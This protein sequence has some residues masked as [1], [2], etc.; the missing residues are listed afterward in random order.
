MAR[1]FV[2]LLVVLVPS[3]TFAATCSPSTYSLGTI[4]PRFGMDATQMRSVLAQASDVWN[5]LGSQSLFTFATSSGIR[6]SLVYDNR[7]KETDAQKATLAQFGAIKTVFDGIELKLATIA[8]STQEE[9]T[10]LSAQYAAYKAD[11]DRFNADVAASNAHGGASPEDY[12]SFQS[13]Q[14]MLATRFSALKTQEV[15]LNDRA[16]RINALGDV[17][18]ALA[19]TVNAYIAQYNA[20]IARIGDYEEG[21]YGESG[22][23]RVIVIYQFADRDQLIRA[24]AHEFGHA[25]GLEHLSDTTALMYAKNLATTTV[26]SAADRQEYV[27]VCAH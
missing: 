10:A 19:K 20:S 15:A 18:A 3:S 11:E 2:L 6:V 5:P 24:L 21:Y 27:R 26:L 12:A 9:Q 4:D 7:Q 1:V 14:Q 8:S 17:L 22:A 16:A 23:S 13:R 25:L